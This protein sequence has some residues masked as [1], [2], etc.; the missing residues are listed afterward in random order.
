MIFT[1][2]IIYSLKKKIIKKPFIGIREGDGTYTYRE[3]K[4]AIHYNILDKG[5][6]KQTVR[7]LSIRHRLTESEIRNIRRRELLRNIF[8]YQNLFNLFQ[9]RILM[10]FIF[11]LA[12]IYFGVIDPYERKVE[13]FR[14]IISRAIGIEPD[15]VEFRGGLLRI[16]AKRRIAY[17]EDTEYISFT[18]DPLSIFSPKADGYLTRWNKD[19]GYTVNPLSYDDAGNVWIKL[20][21]GWQHGIVANNQLKW[22]KPRGISAATISGHEINM[23]DKGL[24][25]ID[26]K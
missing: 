11:G 26:Q 20:H 15:Q 24:R 9:P 19:T 18:L 4:F 1:K 8:R 7:I 5:G 16:F 13:R 23:E 3:G 14:W 6:E 22:D 25:I 17:K 21:S 10:F 12:I 2:I